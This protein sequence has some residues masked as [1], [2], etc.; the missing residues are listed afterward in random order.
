MLHFNDLSFR[1][2]EIF[3]SKYSFLKCLKL[4]LVF[5]ASD[6]FF[7]PCLMRIT[8]MNCFVHLKMATVWDHSMCIHKPPLWLSSSILHLFFDCGT[9]WV[10]LMVFIA[11]SFTHCLYLSKVFGSGGDTVVFC[12][13]FNSVLLGKWKDIR[14]SPGQLPCGQSVCGS[15]CHCWLLAEAGHGDT[16]ATGASGGGRDLGTS[17]EG[18]WDVYLGA[19]QHEVILLHCQM[20]LMCKWW[21]LW[22]NIQEI[23]SRGGASSCHFALH[24]ERGFCRWST[25]CG[26]QR[27]PLGRGRC[28]GSQEGLLVSLQWVVE[29]QRETAVLQ[30]CPRQ[31]RIL[32]ARR[33]RWFSRG[34][35]T[36]FHKRYRGDRIL[37]LVFLNLGNVSE[38]NQHA[39][40]FVCL[41]DRLSACFRFCAEY[42]IS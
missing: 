28:R 17:F 1:S 35:S 40:L 2:C 21:Y 19:G 27:V 42:G 39:C 13:C 31:G 16:A 5:T 11:G 14:F 36:L 4:L 24:H 37:T 7:K 29:E 12:K 30:E 6:F 38:V 10:R 8:F 18:V 41:S 26:H 33:T 34:S 23:C 22:K 20:P 15:C 32:L 3:I 25:C 9:V